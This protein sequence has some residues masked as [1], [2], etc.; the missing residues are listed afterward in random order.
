MAAQVERHTQ[1]LEATVRQRT[2]ALEATN[3]EMAQAHR[4]IESSL[5]YASLIQRA[6]LPGETLDARLGNRYGVMWRPRDQVGGDIFIFHATPAG[7]L[8][9]VVDCAGHGVPGA[10]MT[11]LVKASIDHAVLRL[12]ATDPAA[13]L[14]DVDARCRELLQRE[15]LTANLATDI[16]MGLVWIDDRQRRMRF[17]GAKMALHVADGERLE[18]HPGGRRALMQ[19]RRMRY[20]NLELALQPGASYTLCSDGFLD[21]AGG[22]RGFGFGRQRFAEMLTR[23]AR[24]TP[25][26][27]VAAFAEELA[28]YSGTH[29]QRDDITLLVFQPDP[30]GR[31]T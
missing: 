6:I 24:L 28:A 30:G 1:Q 15:A 3:Q 14:D 4:Q 9:G 19:K 16:D 13:I 17:A 23:H 8:L 27:Q 21:Q 18:S 11:M 26:D 7:Y 22:E 5:A 31:P 2:A 20:A 12:G 10:L 25:K 29:P